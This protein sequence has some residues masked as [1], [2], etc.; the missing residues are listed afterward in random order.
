MNVSCWIK[1]G[2]LY[3]KSGLEEVVECIDPSQAA[4]SQ[5]NL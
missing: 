3:I 2:I 1:P 5:F 4:L